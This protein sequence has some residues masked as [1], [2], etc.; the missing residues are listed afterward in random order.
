MHTFLNAI[1][2]YLKDRK[3]VIRMMEH[4]LE[5][6]EDFSKDTSE[7]VASLEATWLF[8]HDKNSRKISDQRL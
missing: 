1:A 3:V 7:V 8:S 6:I 4:I 5:A 2:K